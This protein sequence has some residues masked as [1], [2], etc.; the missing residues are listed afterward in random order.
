MVVVVVGVIFVGSGMGLWLI[1]VI[2][3]NIFVLIGM[4]VYMVGFFYFIVVNLVYWF[5]L[6]EEEFVYDW[7]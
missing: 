1:W 6:L 7:V 2:V 5:C 3:K 4:V